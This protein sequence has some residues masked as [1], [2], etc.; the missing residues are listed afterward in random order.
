MI[1]LVI[2]YDVHGSTVEHLYVKKQVNKS[3]AARKSSQNDSEGMIDTKGM[4]DSSVDEAQSMT[5]NE[6]RGTDFR[7]VRHEQG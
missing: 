2:P 7:K 3:T 1:V 4:Q 6:A 5:L